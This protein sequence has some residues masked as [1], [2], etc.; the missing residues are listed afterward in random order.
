MAAVCS[1]VKLDVGGG[2]QIGLPKGP[3]FLWMGLR[4]VREQE[5]CNIAW[6]ERV[7]EET[8]SKH[9]ASAFTHAWVYL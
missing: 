1:C 7:S 8:D 2:Q 6:A 9:S 5:K 3:E 4:E